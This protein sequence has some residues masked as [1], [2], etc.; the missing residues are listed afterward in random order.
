MSGV[1]LSGGMSTRMGHE[2]GLVMLAGK[3]LVSY[4]ASVL[5]S[6]ADEIVG[7]VAKDMS[8]QYKIVLKKGYK[9]VEDRRQGYGPLEGLTAAF[10][11][12][13][14]EY[15]LVCPCDTPFLS[16][17]VCEMISSRAKGS[18]GAVPRIGGKFEPLH[19]TY[20]RESAL[21]A[22][23]STIA[24]GKRKPIEAYE[25]LSL[26]YVEEAEL[27]SI[28]PHLL[29]FWNLNSPKDLDLAEQKMVS[30]SL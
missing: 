13:R 18:D 25:K 26:V 3:P 5:E 20:S 8:A 16:P 22:F 4:V 6:V 23:E 1:I 11:A 10:E 12:A 14:G 17:Q 28:D 30:S 2:K 27:R 19:A 7:A 15:A 29:S 9:I 24:E 21:R